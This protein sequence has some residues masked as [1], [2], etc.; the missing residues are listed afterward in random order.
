MHS[1]LDKLVWAIVGELGNRG[2]RAEDFIGEFLTG[3]VNENLEEFV[4]IE[5][6]K[7]FGKDNCRIA[8]KAA[9][10]IFI[11]EDWKKEY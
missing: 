6:V 5:D 2:F 7:K 10:N 3:F 9:I 8:F 4:V 1:T 11:E